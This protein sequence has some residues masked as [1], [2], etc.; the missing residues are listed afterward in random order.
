[1]PRKNITAGYGVGATFDQTFKET[2]DQG[3]QAQHHQWLPLLS[4]LKDS[5]QVKTVKHEG[6]FF[7]FL[8]EMHPGSNSGA[9]GEDGTLP[10]SDNPSQVQASVDYQRSLKGQFEITAES[11]EWAKGDKGT[12]K[13][14][15]KSSMESLKTQIMRLA[16]PGL[17]GDGTGRLAACAVSLQNG[18]SLTLSASETFNSCYPGSRWVHHGQRLGI[19]S[20]AGTGVG[21]SLG[22]SA[23]DLASTTRISRIPADTAVILSAASSVNTNDV[24]FNIGD[25]SANTSVGYNYAGPDGMLAAVDARFRGTYLNIDSDTY[26][27]WKGIESHNSGTARPQTTTLFYQN[28]FK[29]GR[30]VGDIKHSPVA[31]S[32]PDVY[33]DLLRLM[34]PNVQY[35]PTK[36]EMGFKPLTLMINGVGIPIRLDYYCP[37]YWFMLQPKS[38]Y[39]INSRPLGLVTDRDGN[40]WERIANKTNFNAMFWWGLN[41]YTKHRNNHGIIK[42][43]DVTIFS[44]GL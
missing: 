16:G 6:K 22:A 25:L 37:K 30:W 3:I 42:D 31:W 4:W 44:Q 27:L 11:I 13:D 17:W 36:L 35:Q 20:S 10:T 29:V 9:V 21:V 19:L 12:F 5:N 2:F 23:G 15:M 34:E 26:D 39:F 40:A 28:Y 14:S 18:T 38:L 43:L 32:N 41:T 33:T 7:T 8:T 1:M 24:I